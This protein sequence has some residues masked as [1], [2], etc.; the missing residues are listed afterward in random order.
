MA[1]QDRLQ[2]VGSVLAS[3][4]DTESARFARTLG[5]ALSQLERQLLGLVQQARA[6]KPGALA[7]VGRLLQLR[8]ELRTA[9]TTSGYRRL[10][11]R[12]SL[13]AVERMAQAVAS[14]RAVTGAA[15]LGRV[16]GARLTALARLMAADL[17][18]LGDAAAARLWRAVAL[19]I[20]GNAPE[21]AILAALATELDTTRA[22]V[23]SLFDTQ[24]SIVGRQIVA[25]ADPPEP[26]QA[27][28][29]VGPVDGRVRP[30]CREQLGLVYTKD[31]IDALDNGQLPNVF[32]TGGG[33][34]CRHSF[35]A[36]S[37][38]ELVALA[39]TGQRAPGY[40]E[41][42]AAAETVRSTRRRAA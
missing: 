13:D 32:L 40:A 38:P 16:T 26:A 24:V 19:A 30:F 21:P 8:R 28:L 22:Q 23:Q 35:L 15:S 6:G 14:R 27:Y 33:Y 4:A 3:V 5:T 11:E 36:V 41:R 1:E 37:D 20:Y 39:N 2:L 7:K 10:V 9:L 25:E 29:Y 12:A 17:L 18:G 31:R 42:I 34:N